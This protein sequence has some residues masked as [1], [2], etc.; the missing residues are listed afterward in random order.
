MDSSDGLLDGSW[1]EA[2][3][4]ELDAVEKEL[5]LR[6]WMV[7]V[8]QWI[9]QANLE[10]VSKFSTMEDL[11]DYVAGL[12]DN[13]KRLGLTEMSQVQIATK[14]GLQELR[15]IRNEFSKPSNGALL[16]GRKRKRLQECDML[17][18]SPSRSFKRLKVE[19]IDEELDSLSDVLDQKLIIASQ[20]PLPD[21][22]SCESDA[23]ERF[24]S[25][26]NYILLIL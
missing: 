10:L 21:S 25:G 8:N 16:G 7:F 6:R 20:T 4:K 22:S 5:F 17:L 13:V 15:Y 11:L 9:K 2:A 1:N 3:V 14:L 23:S 12:V 18:G 26:L 19:K 24:F